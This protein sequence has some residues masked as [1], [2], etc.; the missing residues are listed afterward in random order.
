[1]V[2]TD[3]VTIRWLLTIQEPS[4]KL[5]R[6]RLYLVE[7]NFEVTNKKMMDKMQ[8]DALL[9]LRMQAETI[10]DYS[11]DIPAFMLYG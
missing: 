11:D 1:M 7:L 4:E 10:T 2:F 3:Y 6:W 9:R 5:M 8:A